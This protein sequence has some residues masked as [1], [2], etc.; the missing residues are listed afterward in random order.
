MATNHPSGAVPVAAAVA[1]APNTATAQAAAASPNFDAMQMG[2]Y[3]S[4]VNMLADTSS[5]DEFKLKAA[6]E[7]SEHFELITQCSGFQSFLELAMRV[8]L[9]VLQENE[10]MFITEF[11]MQQVRKLI[12]EMIHRLPNSEHVRQYVKPI[13][14]LM[15]KLLHT[16]NEENVLVCLRIL[17]DIHKQYRP[18]FHTEILDF[19]SYLKKIYT[20][21]PKNM[22]AMLE[23][24]Q[25]IKLKDLKDLNLDTLLPEIFTLTPLQVEK[26]MP[27]GKIS[28]SSVGHFD[29][30][31]ISIHFNA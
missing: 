30:L 26:K 18:P 29:W 27:D 9:K 14:V 10:P 23:P 16:E 31:R 24:R 20:D 3:R 22:P 5:K 4:Y 11:S 19:L 21:L 12:L 6:Q 13:I 1:A 17:I 8:F 7:L 25:S 15:I 2:H 28:H